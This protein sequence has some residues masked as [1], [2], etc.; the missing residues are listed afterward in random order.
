MALDFINEKE[1][2]ERKREKRLVHLT[3]ELG[4]DFIASLKLTSKS[5]KENAEF[6]AKSFLDYIFF[7]QHKE[8]AEIHPDQVGHFLL[9]YAPRKLSLTKDLLSVIPDEI[10]RLF[11]FLNAN[12]YLKNIN[13]LLAA[14]KNNTKAFVKIAGNVKKPAAKK[15]KA[16]TASSALKT[17]TDSKVGRND[18]C[19]CGSG[20]KYK[21]CCGQEK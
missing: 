5:E 10:A 1:T 14:L 20:K 3:N 6:V 13:P 7:E 9:E 8:I 19:P 2:E 11:K 16:L 17:G 4:R 12:G 15:D 18:P 21:K